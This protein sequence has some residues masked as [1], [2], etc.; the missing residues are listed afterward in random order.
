MCSDTKLIRHAMKSLTITMPSRFHV[1]SSC[2]FVL[3]HTSIYIHTCTRYKY[4]YTLG[5]A[6]TNVIGSTNSF[7]I[8]S[9]RSSTH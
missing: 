7:V 5:N 3:I 2:V 1:S 8:A 4:M 6:R 9:V